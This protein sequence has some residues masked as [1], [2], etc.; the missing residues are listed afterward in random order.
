MIELPS[1]LHRGGYISP[2]LGEL[3]R[4]KLF[5]L[6]LLLYRGDC[7]EI[8]V[9]GINHHLAPI[10]VR[11]N[12]SLT[13][14]K[15]IEVSNLLLD[16]SQEIIILATC[17]RNEI[18]FASDNTLETIEYIENFYESYFEYSDSKKYIFSKIGEDA[19]MHLFSVA[20]GL[21]SMVLGESQI[22]QQIK[23]ALNFSM[24]LKFSQ[25]ILN[26]LFMDALAVGKKIRNNL[27]ISE[28]P[29]STSYIG[30][31]LLLEEMHGFTDKTALLVGVGEIG[32]L[33]L[34]YLYESDIGEVYIT[35][36]SSGKALD[37]LEDFPNLKFVP[38][39]DRYE[40]LSRADI[41]LTATAAPHSVIDYEDFLP[42]T[43][44]LY[45]MDLGLPRD[46][47]PQIG[48]Y[49]GVKIFHLDN[50]VD[51]SEKNINKRKELAS[52]AL[53]LVKEDKE[54]FIDWLQKIEVDP[55]LGSI[56]ERCE[57][58]K[59]DCMDYLN[60]KLNLDSREKKIMKQVL[61]YSL[62]RFTRDLKLNLKKAE[63]PEFA[64]YKDIIAKIMEL[65]I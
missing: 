63:S 46:V 6:F 25:K 14:S 50:L 7:M 65:E 1:T 12:F 32:T 41:L 38:Y 30:I 58:I 55:Y 51:I 35:N 42:P 24:E 62:N 23:C 11:E 60:R 13:E 49:A 48:N 17:N 9:V 16:C 29:I 20:G 2:C 45:V 54:K 3:D 34:K 31:N 36:R 47:D 28:I 57:S 26:R 43:K 56:N 44:P 39:E 59:S 19:I 10:D 40:V 21:D 8:G 15:K 5:Y 33:A 22:L 64:E 52:A 61:T 27:K 37:L 18:Y 53:E 4:I